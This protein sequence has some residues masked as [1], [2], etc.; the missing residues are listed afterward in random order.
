MID[1]NVADDDDF[2]VSEAG[3]GGVGACE[4]MNCRFHIAA[5]LRHLHHHHRHL[6]RC[7]I[8]QCFARVVM[9]KEVLVQG[10]VEARSVKLEM[11]AVVQ[12][13]SQVGLSCAFV[14]VFRILYL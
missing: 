13:E 4:V 7:G 10:P 5:P 2:E 14:F 11:Y 1:V 6:Y 9:S 3:E 8:A 12:H